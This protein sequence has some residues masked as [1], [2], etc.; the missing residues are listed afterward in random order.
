METCLSF[1]AEVQLTF[2]NCWK[3]GTNFQKLELIIKDKILTAIQSKMVCFLKEHKIERALHILLPTRTYSQNFYSLSKG[4]AAKF[5]TKS[6]SERFKGRQSKFKSSWRD[7]HRHNM[8]VTIL[9]TW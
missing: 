5:E 2:K 7:S 8:S 9:P 1:S 3:A 6:Y 4:D